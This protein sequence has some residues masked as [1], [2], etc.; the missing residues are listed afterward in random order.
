VVPGVSLALVV[1]YISR[2]AGVGAAGVGVVCV[3]V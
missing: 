3:C 1:R 2:V